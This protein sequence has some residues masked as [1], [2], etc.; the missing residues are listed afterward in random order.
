MVCIGV[1]KSFDEVVN[2]VVSVE[3]MMVGVNFS[4]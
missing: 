1:G 4:V 2:F 3:S